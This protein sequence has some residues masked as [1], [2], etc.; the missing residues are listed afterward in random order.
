[1]L[2][3]TPSDFEKQLINIA[4]NVHLQALIRPGVPPIVWETKELHNSSVCTVLDPVATAGQ[5]LLVEF[6]GTYFVYLSIY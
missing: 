4:T 1:M 5:R 6:L 2:A 3:V